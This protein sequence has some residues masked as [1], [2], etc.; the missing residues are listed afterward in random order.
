MR[1]IGIDVF[2]RQAKKGQ[3]GTKHEKK[4][5]CVNINKIIDK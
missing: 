4:L 2:G 1:E 3:L 5:T